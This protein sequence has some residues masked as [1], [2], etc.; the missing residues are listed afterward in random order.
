MIFIKANK[1][2]CIRP[3]QRCQGTTR[4]PSL[5]GTDSSHTRRATQTLYHQ[6]VLFIRFISSLQ[7]DRQVS[8]SK[9]TLATIKS[10][11]WS[12]TVGNVT[13]GIKKTLTVSLTMFYQCNAKSIQLSIMCGEEK[14]REEKRREEKRREEK[15]REEKRREEKRREEKRREEKRRE[16]QETERKRARGEREGEGGMEGMD[17]CIDWSVDLKEYHVLAG[18]PVRVKCALF[19]SYIRTNYTMATNAKLRLIWYKNK[20]DAEEPIIFSGH[21][22]SKEDDSIWFRSAE[23]EDNGFYTCVLRF[24]QYIFTPKHVNFPGIGVMFHLNSRAAAHFAN[25][26]KWF[27]LGASH[28]LNCKRDKLRPRLHSSFQC[29]ICDWMRHIGTRLC[30]Y[31]NS[32]Y[33]MKVSMSMT[34]EESDE[35]KCFSSKIRYLEKAEITHSKM[36][37]CRDIED[38]LAPYKQPQMTWYKECE[39]VEWR[40][41][42]D[43]NTTHIWIPEVE[44]GDGGNYTCELQYGSRLVRRTTQLK[45]TAGFYRYAFNIKWRLRLYKERSNHAGERFRINLELIPNLEHT[46]FLHCLLFNRLLHDSERIVKMRKQCEITSSV[47]T[48]CQQNQHRYVEQHSKRSRDRSSSVYLTR[49]LKY[50]RGVQHKVHCVKLAACFLSMHRRF[51]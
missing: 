10:N 25:D 2:E 37:T 22:L 49:L 46:I 21:R 29:D 6:T 20:G 14:R 50:S 17:G 8:I 39:R 51:D 38:Y 27:C 3:R 12:C 32:T 40:S 5:R 24:S 41:S 9:D 23:M 34:V 48:N 30:P 18:E 15:R 42:I 31:T 11:K 19:Y 45:V 47:Q 44:E 4:Q 33:C 16:E 7:L 13:R 36:I 1:R 28:P 35:G 43:V 26:Y